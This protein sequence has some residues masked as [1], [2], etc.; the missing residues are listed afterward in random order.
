MSAVY[1]TASVLPKPGQTVVRVAP[2]RTTN[3]R[4]TDEQTTTQITTLVIGG[5]TIQFDQPGAALAWLVE[6]RAAIN[7]QIGP[8]T[9]D[10]STFVDP[11]K[12]TSVAAEAV[13]VW[14]CR[15]SEPVHGFICTEPTDHEGEHIAG[16]G[17]GGECARWPR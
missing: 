3:Y 5:L 4:W 16:D 14:P 2:Q 1:F 15:A 10:I 8:R 9:V 7:A 11:S 13:P 17:S 6:C 12:T